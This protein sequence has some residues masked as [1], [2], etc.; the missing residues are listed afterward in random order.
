MCKTGSDSDLR[1]TLWLHNRM[2][3]IYKTPKEAADL[4][5]WI[6]S[7]APG[8]LGPLTQKQREII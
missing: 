1:F 7:N 4:A 5:K 3:R 8:A 2:V 6:D